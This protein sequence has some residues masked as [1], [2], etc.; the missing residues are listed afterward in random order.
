MEIFITDMKDDSEYHNAINCEN[1]YW[2]HPKEDGQKNQPQREM[3]RRTERVICRLMTQGIYFA[4]A[5]SKA[6][7][8]DIK[9]NSE[10]DIEIKGLIRCT[11]VD[12]YN[13]ILRA[14]ACEGHWGTYYAWYTTQIMGNALENQL[15]RQ[16][17]KKGKYKTIEL[18]T[19]NIR[20]KMKT[21][22]K[23]DASMQK[24]LAKEKL[25]D[26]C[27]GGTVKLEL[28][29]K[30]EEQDKK[31]DKQKEHE[32]REEVTQILNDM[33]TDIGEQHG[34]LTESPETETPDPSVDDAD[35]NK[36]A[37]IE[38]EMKQ[39]IERVQ[40]ILHELIAEVAAKAAADI[41]A[42]TPPKVPTGKD[43]WEKE[44]TRDPLRTVLLNMDAANN[45]KNAH[46][47]GTAPPR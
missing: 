14:N 47:G 39:G 11:I 38:K 36:D 26:G 41:A 30:Q 46:A 28:G 33:K 40:E 35:D 29:G 45:N 37:A 31:E 24:K 44:R 1:A 15:G 22:L 13:D 4:N 8:E 16:N 23:Q 32:L 34:I 6:A 7:Q 25:S 18:N 27:T 20:N 12:V 42:T 10:N 2:E 5:W 9:G 19:W 43:R 21:W 17:C 3:S